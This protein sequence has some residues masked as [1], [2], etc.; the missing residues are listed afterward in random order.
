[1][2]HSNTLRSRPKTVPRTGAIRSQLEQAVSFSIRSGR[3][4][5]RNYASQVGRGAPG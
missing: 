1:M 5:P 3:E 4:T 2:N